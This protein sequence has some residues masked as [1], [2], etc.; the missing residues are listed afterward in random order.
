MVFDSFGKQK[1]DFFPWEFF[2]FL[3]SLLRIGYDGQENDKNTYQS[4]KL[5][6]Y[7]Y[8]YFYLCR[9]L[10]DEVCSSIHTRFHSISSSTFYPLISIPGKSIGTSNGNNFTKWHNKTYFIALSWAR[11][12]SL[13]SS[14]MLKQ[15]SHPIIFGSLHIAGWRYTIWVFID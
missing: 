6:D 1:R 12:Q 4:S 14:I 2:C 3:R 15:K 13:P 5:D 11:F 8:S 9:R 10:E 7:L